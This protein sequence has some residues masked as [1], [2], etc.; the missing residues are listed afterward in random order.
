VVLRLKI[1]ELLSDGGVFGTKVA[2]K[3]VGT[4]EVGKVL[5]EMV[6]IGVL[7][8]SFGFYELCDGFKIRIKGEVQRGGVN[9]GR[10]M[11]VINEMKEGGYSLD[12]IALEL[13]VT[14]AEVTAV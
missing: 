4:E 9:K 3:V 13:G 7:S 10:K 14:V 6:Q 11:A 12:R 1:V 2:K 8:K 5:N